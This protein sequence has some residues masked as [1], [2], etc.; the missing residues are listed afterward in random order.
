LRKRALGRFLKVLVRELPEVFG[1]AL[2]H[3][4]GVKLAIIGVGRGKAVIILRR[5]PVID[6]PTATKPAHEIVDGA[7]HTRS[8][9]SIGYWRTAG[10][11]VIWRVCALNRAVPMGIGGSLG[12]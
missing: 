12:A 7:S 9:L 10:V 1:G 8:F 4:V 5:F 11:Y 3:R 6:T 2:R